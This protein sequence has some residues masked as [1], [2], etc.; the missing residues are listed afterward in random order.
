MHFHFV[1]EANASN[2]R[3]FYSKHYSIILPIPLLPYQRMIKG[4]TYGYSRD[5]RLGMIG[6]CFIDEHIC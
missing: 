2:E 3:A 6:V 1:P 4:E 5:A